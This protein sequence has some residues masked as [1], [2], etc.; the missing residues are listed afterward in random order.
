MASD[1]FEKALGNIV[2]E[3]IEANKALLEKIAEKIDGNPFITMEQISEFEDIQEMGEI[4][5]FAK[6]TLEQTLQ[7]IIV[8]DE[9]DNR[10]ETIGRV[11]EDVS[12]N[13]TY[14]VEKDSQ[15]RDDDF[16]INDEQTI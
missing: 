9:L 2:D 10:I 3:E 11:I 16:E 7:D 15:E 14:E 1:L 12:K 13:R 8:A 6:A 4:S 5:L